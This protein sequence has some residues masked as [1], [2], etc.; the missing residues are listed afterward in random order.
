MKLTSIIFEGFREDSSIVNGKK[1]STD[2]LGTADTLEDF[3][4]AIDRMPDTIKS[5]NTPINTTTF[6]TSKDY[7]TI[8]PE[9][10]W[11]SDVIT[12]VGKVVTQHIQDGDDLEGIRISSYYGTGPQGS[13]DH[14]INIGIQ[15]KKSR[16]FGD[17]MRSGKHGSLD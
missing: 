5:I 12:T 7:K 16:E 9:G 8:K 6:K 10:S 15:T 1:Y 2:W 11:K 13:D 4:K 14:P 17:A 3:K